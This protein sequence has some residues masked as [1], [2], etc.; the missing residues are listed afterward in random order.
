MNKQKYSSF[1]KRVIHLGLKYL[2]VSVIAA[3]TSF[4]SLICIMLYAETTFVAWDQVVNSICIMLMLPYYPDQKFYSKLCCPC[5]TLCHV[6][7]TKYNSVYANI[8]FEDTEVTQ[9]IEL[10][11]ADGANGSNLNNNISLG[12]TV[13]NS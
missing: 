9:A 12:V 10:T 3:I 5:H 13:T 7:C 2:I 6:C 1:M 8:M 4:T 11:A